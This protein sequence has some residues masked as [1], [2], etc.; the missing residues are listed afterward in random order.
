MSESAADVVKTKGIVPLLPV[1]PLLKREQPEN[2]CAIVVTPPVVKKETVWL[3]AAQLKNIWLVSLSAIVV[4][5][6]SSWPPALLV[7][8]LLKRV[9]PSNIWVIVVTEVVSAMVSVWLN[10]LHPKN[11]L[12][13][14]IR[15]A[16][17][18]NVSAFAASST[19]L[20]LLN[21]VQPASMLDVVVSALMSVVNPRV[22]LNTEQPLNINDTDVTSGMLH[23][24][25]NNAC[26]PVLLVS[27]LLNNAA[28]SNI[29]V[30]LVT[31]SMEPNVTL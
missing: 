11:M 31:R 1:S 13:V 18:V 30:A 25:P 4:R 21:N 3:N 16:V 27:P 10:A 19:V 20:P 26:V 29:L 24:A 23:V 17:V 14:S 7:T 22:W 6:A 5:N 15:V 2:I 8:P 28:P 12:L 9:Q